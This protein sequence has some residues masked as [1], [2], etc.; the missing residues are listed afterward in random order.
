MVP[1]SQLRRSQA[2]IVCLVAVLAVHAIQAVWLFPTLRALV[3]NDHPVIVVDHAIHLYH[4]ALGSRFLREHGTTWGY[5]PFFM[6]G[7]PETPVWD[8]SSNLSILFQSLAG[9]GYHPRAYNIGLL[10]C[11]ILAMVSIPAGAAAAGVEL[12]EIAMAT[13]LGWLYFHCGWPDVFWRSGLFGFVSASCGA[14]LLIGLLLAFERRPGVKRWG[15]RGGNGRGT[16]ARARH[17]ADCDP[18]CRTWVCAHSGPSPFLALIGG[19]P[20][21]GICRPAYQPCLADTALEVPRHP[22]GRL[23]LHGANIRVVPGRKI[24]ARRRR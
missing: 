3:D 14:V 5:D 11:S 12:W 7:Y 24:P 16:L 20:C 18:G 22:V 8:S 17:G 9:G 10:T 19:A 6:A 13:I 1:L 2:A 21:G 23:F 15:G 4:G